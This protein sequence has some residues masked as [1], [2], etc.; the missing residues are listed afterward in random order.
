VRDEERM[1]KG[2]G[3]WGE[4]ASERASERERERERGERERERERESRIRIQRKN[5]TFSILIK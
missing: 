5:I 1:R 4:R 2:E 3:K